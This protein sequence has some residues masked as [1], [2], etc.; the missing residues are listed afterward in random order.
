LTPEGERIE[1]S[2]KRIKEMK[3][4]L[5]DLVKDLPKQVPFYISFM[6]FTGAA[7]KEDPELYKELKRLEQKYDQL[8][9]DLIR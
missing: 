9:D 2:V 7:A 5:W 6:S 3:P 1:L 8:R 4:W